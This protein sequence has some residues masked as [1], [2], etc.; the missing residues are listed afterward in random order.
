MS[1]A[2]IIAEYDPFHNGHLLHL[3][4]T[5]KLAPNGVV[6]VLGGNFTQRGAPAA[7]P[8]RVRAKMA[9]EA[10]ADLVLELP[11]PFSMARAETFASGGVEI[12][13]ALGV[14][15]TLSFGSECGDL[16]L[17]QKAADAVDSEKTQAAVR[18]ALQ[19][20]MTYAAARETAV[21]ACFGDTLSDIL[22]E[23]NNILGVEY[24][25]ACR[26][27]AP[28]LSCHT[29]LRQGAAHD[30]ERPAGGVASASFLR[31]A[32]LAGKDVGAFVPSSTAAVMKEAM[33]V[34]LAPADI[35]QLETAV[36]AFLRTTPEA[37]E[38]VPDLSEG[39]SNRIY[40]AARTARTLEEL[41]DT[42][43]TKRYTHARIRRAVLS[44]YLGVQKADVETGVPYLRV[45]GFSARGRALL[46]TA[47]KRAAKPVVLRASDVRPLGERARRLFA[48]EC[49][50]SDVHALLRPTRGACG[51][52]MTEPVLRV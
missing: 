41:Y 43:K 44:A 49:A 9:L 15:D 1:V 50:A 10:G 46:Q 24:L 48:L 6:V 11:L 4:E 12:L 31:E 8:K 39:L 22:H 20:G 16:S 52:E 45:L 23:P 42:A 25:R 27:A 13:A 2:G 35:Q 18:A 5:K 21:R 3:H 29:V 36:L 32:L 40:K 51:E 38:A 7:F 33:R 26:R 19:S 17:L 14:V 47:A 37:L 28:Q 34:G 30:A